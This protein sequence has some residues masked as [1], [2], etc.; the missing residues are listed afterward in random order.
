MDSTSAPVR[1]LALIGGE[2]SGKSTLARE[3][4]R[5]LDGVI[6]VEELRLFVE[7]HDRTPISSEQ[8][9]ILHAQI[10][11]ERDAITQAQESGRAW[12]IGDPAAL[13]TA[14]YS[15]A[16]FADESLLAPAV[17]HQSKYAM[18]VWCDIDLP[19]EPDG[20]QRD[21]PHERQRIHEVIAEVVAGYDLAVVRVDGSV[22]HR[23]AQVVAA[24]D[25]FE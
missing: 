3:L 13:M 1:T 8:L 17:A 6:V 15:V 5:V 9:P 18:T 19:W 12:V 20:A 7:A 4:A 24:L 11:A 16:Y 10:A 22:E 2:C 14:I 25:Q 21:G 23:V